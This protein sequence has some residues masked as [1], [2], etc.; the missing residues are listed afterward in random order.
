MQKREGRACYRD[1]SYSHSQG[2]PP[3]SKGTMVLAAVGL[4]IS[5]TAFRC[6]GPDPSSPDTGGAGGAGGATTSQGGAGGNCSPDLQNDV[7]NC[8]ACG[9]ACDPAGTVSLSCH[10]GVC[11]SVCLPGSK[12]I[13]HPVA[14]TKDDG[15]EAR[16][17]RV[18]VTSSPVPPRFGPNGGAPSADLI[19][20]MAALP[21]A[22]P[23]MWRAWTSDSTTSPKTRFMTPDGPYIQ[24]NGTPVADNWADLID[25]TLLHAI[26]EDELGGTALDVDVWTGT[27]PDGTVSMAQSPQGGTITNCADWTTITSDVD[28]AAVGRSSSPDLGWTEGPMPSSCL[29]SAHLYCFEQ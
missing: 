2:E 25:G 6:P 4:L 24:P 28:F 26:D 14:P 21:L 16:V 18:F 9:R 20:Q 8:G 15:C 13:A 17:H 27:S 22:G 23:A 5:T 11:D 7:D 29:Q 1:V 3:I 10:L 19:C 12:N